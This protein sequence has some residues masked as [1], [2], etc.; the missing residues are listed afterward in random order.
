MPLLPAE[1]SIYPDDLLGQADLP[2]AVGSRSWYVLHTKPRQEKSLARQ[3][4]KTRV[5]FF[6]PLVSKRWRSRRHT[7]TSF[8]PLFSGYVFLHGT[9]EERLAALQTNRVLGSLDVP[10][11]QGLHR[12]LYQ[13]F[14]LI[15]SGEAVAPEDNLVP[16][17][18][19]EVRGGPLMGLTGTIL[20]SA[21]GRRFVVQVDFIHRGASVVMDE[22]T[23]VRLLNE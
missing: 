20:K 12:D 3:L 8:V 1:P 4:H 10:D 2:E 6:L 22:H 23:L 17:A 14:K 16:G 7:L 5:P 15:A 21:T 9:V 13:I 18:R 19:V 11:Q